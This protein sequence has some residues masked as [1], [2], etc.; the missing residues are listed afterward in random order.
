MARV[1]I[2]GILNVTPDSFYDGGLF[3]SH[4]RAVERAC[5]MEN[6]GADIIDVGGESS[7]PGALP[8][9]VDEEI[10]RVCPVIEAIAQKVNVPLS[11]DTRKFEVARLALEAGASIVNDI[12]GLTGDDRIAG[13]VA[14][15]NA[16]IVLMHMKGTPET[17]QNGPRYDDIIAEINNFLSR[18]VEAA[19]R[20]GIKKEKII[21]D[22]GIGFGKTLEDNYHIIN[23]LHH[24]KEL[25]CPLLI[26]LSRKS[27]IGRLYSDESADRLPATI[28]L[29]A[30]AIMNGADIVRVHDVREHGLAR[31]SLE[32][33]KRVS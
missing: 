5:D 1:K 25:G 2:M 3:N 32:M 14:D 20:K 30:A 26:G 15:H 21:L 16:S 29:N 4:D 31:E 7:R 13:L 12:S 33:L 28:A 9:T 6:E 22:P 27:L 23:N 17:M 8:V 18:A 19:L 11:V 10:K 24:F